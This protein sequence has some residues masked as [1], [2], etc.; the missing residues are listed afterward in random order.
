MARPQKEGLEYFPIDVTMF[1][2]TDDKTY[3]IE[4]KYGM[5][6]VGLLIKLFQLIYGNNGYY[7]KWSDKETLIFAKQTGTDINVIKNFI[8]DCINE[9]IFSKVIFDMYGVLTSRGIQKRYLAATDRRK[10]VVLF[11]EYALAELSE[12]VNVTFRSV[13]E[14]NNEINVTEITVQPDKCIQKCSSSGVNDLKSTQSKVKESKYI[15][16]LEFEKF[17]SEYPR[18]EDKRRSF[19][20]W[21]TC[22]KTY[23]VDQLMTA[24]R[25]Y[26]KAKA[27]KEIEYIK[28]SAN[29]IGKEKPFE[30]YLELKQVEQKSKYIDQTNYEPR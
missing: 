17:Y 18:P 13:N 5:E 28:S 15:Y 25:N 7:R 22:L 1:T 9:G 29:F 26:K 27:G 30:D 2:P 6:G 11:Q 12:N 19:N 4:A 24:C 20:N 21:K 8:L 16:T 23:S 14:C 3:Y 10:E